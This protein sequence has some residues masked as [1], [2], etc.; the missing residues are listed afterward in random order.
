LAL[1]LARALSRLKS[2]VVRSDMRIQLLRRIS[3]T[4]SFVALASTA[5]AVSLPT[6]A[7]ASITT[8]FRAPAPAMVICDQLQSRNVIIRQ[9]LPSKCPAGWTTA[10]PFVQLCSQRTDLARKA[11]WNAR[12]TSCPQGWTKVTVDPGLVCTITRDTFKC[13]FPTGRSKV[14]VPPTATT[15]ATVAPTTTTTTTTVRPTTTT[16]APTTTTTTL[17]PTTTVA[18]T[19]AT[20]APTTTTLSPSAGFDARAWEAE[21]LRL[22]N[23]ERQSAGLNPVTACGRLARAALLH[24]NR[25]LEGQFFGHDDPG[26]GTKIADRIR[27]TGYLDSAN[28]WRVAE[29]IAM[30]YSS[31]S[32]TMIGWMNSPGHRTN[33][34]N[35][36]F[37]HLGVGVSIG[38]WEAWR[39]TFTNWSSA[40]MATQNFGVGGAC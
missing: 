11:F 35:P 26:T 20:V 10:R 18:T 1:P 7:R 32:A 38:I 16:V 34:L 12:S 6:Q 31:A 15:T 29:N 27:S 30:G 2:V 8:R 28:G 25:M 13:G 4:I 22:T 39:N 17:R 5:L 9:Q 14:T 21:I 24:S 36:E 40:T 37:T 33:I 19:T 3:R 23:V